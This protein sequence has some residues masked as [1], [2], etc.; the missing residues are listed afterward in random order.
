MGSEGGGTSCV[1]AQGGKVNMVGLGM[2]FP[3][4]CIWIFSH[5]S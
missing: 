2:D 4:W 1:A 5:L 3:T